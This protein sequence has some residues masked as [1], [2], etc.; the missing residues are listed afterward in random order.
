MLVERGD[1]PSEL[2]WQNM[3]LSFKQKLRNRMLGYLLFLAV[4]CGSTAGWYGICILHISLLNSN[5]S[6]LPYFPIAVG[7]TVNF[8]IILV[9]QLIKFV[10]SR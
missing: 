6:F 5:S 1:Y 7:G 3:H 2:Y 10:N 9:N 4:F 8:L